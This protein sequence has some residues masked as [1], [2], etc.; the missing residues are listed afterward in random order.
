MEYDVVISASIRPPS[1]LKKLFTLARYPYLQVFR[2]SSGL[3]VSIL[4]LCLVASL[5]F[6]SLLSSGHLL[7]WLLDYLRLL[8][9][10]SLIISRAWDVLSSRSFHN[11]LT[12]RSLLIRVQAMRRQSLYLLSMNYDYCWPMARVASIRSRI[13]WRLAPSCSHNC[14][15]VR[16]T[17]HRCSDGHFSENTPALIIGSSAADQG[18]KVHADWDAG[19][20]RSRTGGVV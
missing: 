10:R 16:I 6:S 15:A 11:H 14:C 17:R 1:A 18:K 13:M 9:S 7:T 4:V 12:H 20:P 5:A 19:W 8:G 3:F 2:P